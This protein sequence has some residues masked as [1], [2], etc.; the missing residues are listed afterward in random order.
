MVT[1]PLL[2]THVRTQPPSRFNNEYV[3]TCVCFSR[4][5]HCKQRPWE[6]RAQLIHIPRRRDRPSRSSTNDAAMHQILWNCNTINSRSSREG[7]SPKITAR[8]VLHF[9][10]SSF[11]PFPPST[12]RFRI[13]LSRIR[14][15]FFLF[16]SPIN[17]YERCQFTHKLL[18][19]SKLIVIYIAL[20]R[21]IDHFVN[22]A[23]PSGA[24]YYL[25]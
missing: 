11:S 1:W 21:I 6:H 13:N 15:H 18:I 22:P 24:K 16:Y 9:V 8:F 5:A 23:R 4:A 3:H 19:P 17:I 14:V 7:G 12:F 25:Y 2:T 10:F 20:Y